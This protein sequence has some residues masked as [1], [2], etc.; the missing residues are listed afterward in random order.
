MKQAARQASFLNK[1][2][3]EQIKL[4]HRAYVSE[5]KRPIQELLLQKS[6]SALLFANS[7]N[8]E[9]HYRVCLSEEEIKNLLIGSTDI[10][11][12]ICRIGTYRST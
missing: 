3:Y 7:N 6:F 5:H 1:T 4:V 2:T 11:K 10:F 12:R 9:N 8:S